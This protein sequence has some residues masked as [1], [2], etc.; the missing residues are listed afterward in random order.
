M[1]ER[2][3]EDQG[4][5]P[6]TVL[7][8]AGY[9]SGSTLKYLEKENIA[10]YIPDKAT[11][12][13]RKELAGNVAEED[14]YSKEFFKYSRDN[15]IYICPENKSLRKTTSIPIRVYRKG[16]GIVGYFQYQCKECRHCGSRKKCTNNRVGRTINRYK[17]E[18]LREEMAQKMRSGGYNIYKQRMK[19]IEPVFG[20]IK[21]NLG[22][23]EFSLR[24][25][26]KTRGEFFLIATAHNLLKIKNWM[27]NT[28]AEIKGG[29]LEYS[30]A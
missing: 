11:N 29:K 6:Q 28:K 23:R 10:G 7:A 2:L 22:F 24:G 16:E 30:T 14:R 19:I 25:F 9:F 3:K 8:D 4:K 18:N 26:I 27:N 15:D 17:D 20:N 5:T 12:D 13:L 1:I 21:Q